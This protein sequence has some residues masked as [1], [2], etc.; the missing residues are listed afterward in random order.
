MYSGT[1]VEQDWKRDVKIYDRRKAA[2]IDGDTHTHTHRTETLCIH[3]NDVSMATTAVRG[4]QT[5]RRSSQFMHFSAP[6]VYTS[7]ENGLQRLTPMTC[8]WDEA[9][10]YTIH[11]H[12]VGIKTAVTYRGWAAFLWDAEMIDSC[13]YRRDARTRMGL[14]YRSIRGVGLSLPGCKMRQRR[15]RP[16][17]Q[18]TRRPYMFNCDRIYNITVCTHV[19]YRGDKERYL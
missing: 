5:T 4:W 15:R 12:R 18:T 14:I 17:R 8:E 19:M 7:V 13:S 10:M 11:T 6:T 9:R 1:L 3:V 2:V 16:L